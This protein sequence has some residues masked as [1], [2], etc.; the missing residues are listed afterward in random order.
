MAR[1][2]QRIEE[3]A[4]FFLGTFCAS[5]V[6]PVRQARPRRSGR[7]SMLSSALQV[8]GDGFNHN[9]MG[10]WPSKAIGVSS[11]KEIQQ[12]GDFLGTIR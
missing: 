7:R 9:H 8:H 12:A 11:R 5:L 3:P 10:L 6:S 2:A 4:H 1:S